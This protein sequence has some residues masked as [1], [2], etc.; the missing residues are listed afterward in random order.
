MKLKKFK[1]NLSNE[2]KNKIQ[3]KFKKIKTNLK[4]EPDVWA[5]HA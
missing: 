5:A 3:S 4:S 2:I 1:Q